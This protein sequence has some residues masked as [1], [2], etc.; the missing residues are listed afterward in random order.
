MRLGGLRFEIG[1]PNRREGILQLRTAIYADELGYGRQAAEWGP[2]DER[3]IHLLAISDAGAPIAM[4]R[5]LGP[6]ARPF[7]METSFDPSRFLR[8]THPPAEITRFCIAPAFRRVTRAMEVYV[9]LIR[10]LYD[11]CCD[12]GIDDVFICATKS[13]QKLYEFV[14][15]EALTPPDI[16]YLPFGGVR[17]LLMRLQIPT[18]AARYLETNHLLKA[19]FSPPVSD[20]GSA[21]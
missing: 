1:G 5:L 8:P 15:F 4:M 12:K 3:A 9:G 17:H 21:Q 18:L 13:T 7:E 16:E 20:K 14:L 11:T 19:A 6:T 10:L 2:T